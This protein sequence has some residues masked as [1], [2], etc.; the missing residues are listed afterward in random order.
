MTTSYVIADSIKNFHNLLKEFNFIQPF[1]YSPDLSFNR[2][3][4]HHNLSGFLDKESDKFK[5]ITK[6]WV[7]T[8]WNRSNISLLPQNSRIQQVNDRS[9][10]KTNPNVPSLNWKFATIDVSLLLTTN[11]PDYAER[12]EEII[13]IR[14]QTFTDF[15][16]DFKDLGIFKVS[17][18]GFSINSWDKLD[19]DKFGSLLSLPITYKLNY[20]I[21][22]F[23]ETV[24]V[25]HQFN[26]AEYQLLFSSTIKDKQIKSDETLIYKEK[27]TPKD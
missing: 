7:I 13:Q 9:M 1:I 19:H 21:F 20:Q 3:D 2:F 8:Q 10:I 24:K 16:S 4:N 18:D 12:L 14:C 27:I 6:E 15:T 17:V 23:P 22:D 11:Y 26:Y 25:I 5:K